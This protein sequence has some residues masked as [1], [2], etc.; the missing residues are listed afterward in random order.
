M[1]WVE[2]EVGGGWGGWRMRW[3]EDGIAVFWS[4]STTIDNSITTNSNSTTT[5][6]NHNSASDNKQGEELRQRK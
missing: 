5:T 6:T 2:D 1:G 3:V 4:F